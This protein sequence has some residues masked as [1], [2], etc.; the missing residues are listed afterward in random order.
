[1]DFSQAVQI[2][3]AKSDYSDDEVFEA[4]H[5]VAVGVAHLVRAAGADFD[6][7]NHGQWLENGDYTGT[8]TAQQIADELLELIAENGGE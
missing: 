5:T 1:M 4:R 7:V 3:S 6:D 2:L 8:E